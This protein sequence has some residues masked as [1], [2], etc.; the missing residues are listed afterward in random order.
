MVNNN[1]LII[2]A[3]NIFVFKSQ[4]RQLVVN[5]LNPSW[6]QAQE[7]TMKTLKVD[8]KVSQTPPLLLQQFHLWAGCIMSSGSQEHSE[9]F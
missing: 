6:V 2:Y 8:H 1:I 9:C 3:S 4:Q 5:T 7:K